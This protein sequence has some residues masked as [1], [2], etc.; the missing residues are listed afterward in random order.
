MVLANSNPQLERAL[1]ALNRDPRNVGAH[2]QAGV[3][4]SQEDKWEKSAYHLKK[5]L[6][7]DKNN[8]LILVKLGDVL[9]NTRR[10]SDALKYAR[11][12]L[13]K[14]KHDANALFS[15]GQD[16]FC[17]GRQPKSPALG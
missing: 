14:D 11:K 2:L 17:H 15:D 7:G 12:M 13:A 6:A 4:Y 3:F 8:P 5:A 9:V 16:I 10:P 1:A